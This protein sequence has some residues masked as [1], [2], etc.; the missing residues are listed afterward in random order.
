MQRRHNRFLLVF[1]LV[2]GALLF[3][4][5]AWVL[6]KETLPSDKTNPAKQLTIIGASPSAQALSIE[7]SKQKQSAPVTDVEARRLATQK[8][9]YERLQANPQRTDFQEQ[10]LQHII[11]SNRYPPRN[12]WL[13]PAEPDPVEQL[14]RPEQ[15]TDTTQDGQYSLQLWSDKRGYQQGETITLYGRQIELAS[16]KPVTTELNARLIYAE[17]T[18]V[19]PVRFTDDDGDGT[20]TAMIATTDTGNS[21]P[22]GLYTV[23]VKG[24]HDLR[25][26]LAFSL[27][28]PGARLTGH[29]RDH[30]ENG[31][32]IIQAEV[33]VSVE[34]TYYLRGTLYQRQ[35]SEQKFYAQSRQPLTAG[36]QWLSL[37][38]HGYLFQHQQVNGPYELRN[39][40]LQKIDFPS[41]TIE[42]AQ[43]HF[44]TQAYSYRQFTGEP[45]LLTATR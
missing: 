19:G 34:A 31:N 39:I 25:E 38:F 21:L 10:L 32:L 16:G 24:S 13:S 45:Y 27:S 1:L 37:S 43:P 7:Y 29:Y 15:R 26:A 28:Q 33:N 35:S 8:S 9:L 2:V 5:F 36:T 30:I 20:Y 44:L 41:Q 11:S 23:R 14:Q 4:R 17:L 18:T 40:A 12:K 6:Q 3:N 42:F 22:D